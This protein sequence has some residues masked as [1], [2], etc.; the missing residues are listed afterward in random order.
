MCLQISN[1]N[2]KH[3]NVLI[4]N[5]NYDFESAF[6]FI[7]YSKT[8]DIKSFLSSIFRSVFLFLEGIRYKIFYSWLSWYPR[9]KCIMYFFFFFTSSSDL[10]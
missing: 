5:I 8:S 7:R 1:W 2:I 4:Y 3:T 9:A 10:I 6:F